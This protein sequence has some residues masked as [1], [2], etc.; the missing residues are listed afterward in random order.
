MFDLLFI[1]K[2][3]ARKNVLSIEK[4]LVFCSYNNQI[5]KFSKEWRVYIRQLQSE[6]VL[7]AGSEECVI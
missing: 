5:A 6:E 3:R 4:D 1:M 2:F 7:Q